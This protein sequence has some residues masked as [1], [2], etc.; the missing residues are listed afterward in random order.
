MAYNTD[1]VYTK[2]RLIGM[3]S[4]NTPNASRA[5]DGTLA[6]LATAGADADEVAFIIFKALGPVSKGMIRIF[7]FNNVLST[8]LLDEVRVEPNAASLIGSTW[9]KIWHVRESLKILDSFGLPASWA[10][11][12]STVKPESFAAFAFAGSYTA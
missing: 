12:L 7:I 8:L 3:I 9:S 1:P 5:G 10:I 4:F 2:A 11:K 6:T